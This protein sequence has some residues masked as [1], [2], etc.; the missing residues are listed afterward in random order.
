[1]TQL[2][3]ATQL[4]PPVGKLPFLGLDF[5]IKSRAEW[6][7]LLL[8]AGQ[9]TPFQYLVTPNV[10]HV[11]SYHEGVVPAE[12]YSGADYKV[13]DSRILSKLASLRGLKLE[14]Y[15]G[16][17]LVRDFLADPRS[18]ALRIAVF[19][20]T[21]EDFSQLKAIYPDHDLLWIEAPI[22]K[23]GTPAWDD[24]V[25]LLVD[26]PFD[27]LLSCI[28][29]P[30][31]ELMC[32]D[33]QAAGRTHGLGICAGA[34]LDFLTGKQARAPEWMKKGN[35]EWL[36]RLLSDPK[37]LWH[38]YLVRGPRIFLLFLTKK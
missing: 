7:D 11:V 23:R 25:R 22:L 17:D 16:S 19:G 27:L 26:T 37:R 28:S 21:A 4:E 8:S 15:P 24:A 31:Q 20:P 30:K 5:D 29:F 1:M 33:V 9:I 18:K 32:N 3:S 36:H 12:V 2:E 6:T 14:A 38:R 13:C 10:D 34:S 35:V